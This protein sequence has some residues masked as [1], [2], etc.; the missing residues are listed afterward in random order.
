MKSWF[1]LCIKK[2]SVVVMVLTMANCLAG[3]LINGWDDGIKKELSGFGDEDK[4][5]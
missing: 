3:Y 4:T 5:R 2:L 1:L